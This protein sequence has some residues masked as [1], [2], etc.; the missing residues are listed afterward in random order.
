M[1]ASKQVLDR[2]MDALVVLADTEDQLITPY[3]SI[4]VLSIGVCVSVCVCA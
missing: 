1:A 4:R 3:L 2:A